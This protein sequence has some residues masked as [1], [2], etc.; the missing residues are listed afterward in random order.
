MNKLLNFFCFPLLLVGLIFL[1]SG[2]VGYGT[3]Y[4]KYIENNTH[5]ANQINSLYS[6]K[7]IILKDP[8]VSEVLS[9]KLFVKIRVKPIN[10]KITSKIKNLNELNN[11]SSLLNKDFDYLDTNKKVFVKTVLPIIINENQNILMT[12]S[13]V[14]N[15]KNKLETFRTLENKEIRTL[16][17]IAKNY[18][19][20]YREKHKLDLVNEILS[21][22]DVI[23]NSIVLAQAAIESG[24]G[25][26]RFAKEHN[27]LFGEYTY[28][29]EKG[30]IP[31]DRDTGKTHLIK[32]FNSL[33]SSVK[34]YFNN[35]NSHYAY[36]EFR[37][38]RKIMRDKNNFSDVNLLVEKLETYAAD[39]NYVNTIRSVIEKNNF[40][41][42]D[43]K[44]I[45]Y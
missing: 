24:W 11:Q 15:L 4:N 31:L 8:P 43:N 29:T 38:I 18:N 32:S 36:R 6:E 17:D 14:E 42:F 39:S 13:F 9:E 44:T 7:E 1:S 37:D 5:T 26:S 20:K 28:D 41:L 21:N 23:P 10:P 2:L 45:S 3:S 19:I 34:S 22:V 33:D 25:S 35:I 27:A 40:K 16:N 30:V 12:R